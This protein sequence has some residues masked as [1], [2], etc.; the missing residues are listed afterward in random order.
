MSPESL[1]CLHQLLDS[2][3]PA[4]TISPRQ[5]GLRKG[6]LSLPLVAEA[7]CCY[8]KSWGS[9]GMPLSSSCVP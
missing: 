8:R 9:V 6:E 5:Q 3:V 7:A 2:E 1:P 4:S